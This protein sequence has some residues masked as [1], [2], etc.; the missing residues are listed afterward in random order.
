MRNTTERTKK[1]P[2]QNR[3]DRFNRAFHR[4]LKGFC[5]ANQNGNG[6]NEGDQKEREILKR[7]E[8][9]ADFADKQGIEEVVNALEHAKHQ[10]G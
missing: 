7:L 2:K 6:G 5:T 3:A 10:R 9:L 4:I 1:M 8:D